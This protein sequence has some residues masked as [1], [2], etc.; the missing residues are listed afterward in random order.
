MIAMYGDRLQRRIERDFTYQPIP[1]FGLVLTC[2]MPQTLQGAIVQQLVF[3]ARKLL[4]ILGMFFWEM[5]IVLNPYIFCFK[6]LYFRIF[7]QDT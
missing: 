2:F 1:N 7:M 4:E 6:K 5:P 3:V